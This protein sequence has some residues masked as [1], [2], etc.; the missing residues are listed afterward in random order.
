MKFSTSSARV[1]RT[2]QGGARAAVDVPEI[3]AW[4]EVRGATFVETASRGLKGAATIRGD[5]TF[6]RS[7]ASVSWP[8]EEQMRPFEGDGRPKLDV[9]PLIGSELQR[10]NPSLYTFRPTDVPSAI[11][12]STVLYNSV[13]CR[14]VT[15]RKGLRDLKPSAWQIGSRATTTWPS[16]VSAPVVSV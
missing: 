10:L 7:F 6:A 8:A 12:E 4:R 3:E 14:L 2:K 1:S 16:R 15:M 9:K 5:R 11:P 13:S